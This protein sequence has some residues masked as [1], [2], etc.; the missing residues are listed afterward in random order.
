MW[1]PLLSLRLRPLLPVLA[2][3]PVL[4]PASLRVAGSK[5]PVEVRLSLPA[6]VVNLPVSHPA[7]TSLLPAEHNVLLQRAARK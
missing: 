3:R 5:I 2:P 4:P 7:L 6:V 1:A